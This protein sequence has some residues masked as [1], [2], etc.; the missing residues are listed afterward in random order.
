MPKRRLTVEPRDDFRDLDGLH[1]SDEAIRWGGFLGT[2]GAFLDVE[3]ARELA[4]DL[5]G[6]PT[7]RPGTRVPTPFTYGGTAAHVYNSGPENLSQL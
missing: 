1:P 7:V 2:A 4:E 3:S 5:M 6:D